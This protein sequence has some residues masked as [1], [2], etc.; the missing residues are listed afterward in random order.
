[1]VDEE[2]LLSVLI[3]PPEK[4]DSYNNTGFVILIHG[5]WEPDFLTEEDLTGYHS[6]PPENNFESVKG[7]ST[8][9]DVGWMNVCYDEAQIET[10][11]YMCDSGIWGD[12]YIRPPEITFN[13]C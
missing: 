3:I 13:W 12:R 4:L 11:T 2:A 9:E 10:S 8:L 1:M 6:P 7:S 5:Q